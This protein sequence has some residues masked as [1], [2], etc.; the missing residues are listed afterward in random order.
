MEARLFFL[1]M[2]RKSIFKS[3]LISILLFLVLKTYSQYDVNDFNLASSA[4]LISPGCFQLTPADY[5]KGGAIWYK[6]RIDLSSDFEI[7][8]SINLGDL[9]QTGADGISFLLQP[10]SNTLGGFGGGLGYM[11]VVPSLAVEFD[12]WQNDDPTYDHIALVKNGRPEHTINP[13]NTLQGPFELMPQ[14]GNAEDGKFHSVKI[15]WNAKDK[16]FT[17]SF[18]GIVKIQY[19]G[20]IVKDIF[21]SNPYVYW[22]FTAA[23]AAAINDHRVCFTSYSVVDQV[24]PVAKLTTPS[25]FCNNI[26]PLQILNDSKENQLNV[27]YKWYVNNTLVSEDKDLDYTSYKTGVFQL[28]LLV[29][30]DNG[31]RDSVSKSIEIVDTPSVKLLLGSKNYFC[32]DDSLLISSISSPGSGSITSS[33]WYK[34]Q[35][36]MTSSS[37]SIYAKEEGEYSLIIKNSNGCTSSSNVSVQ[38]KLKPVGILKGPSANY[39]CQ[40]DSVLITAEGGKTYQWYRDGLI[41]NGVSESQ[42]YAKIAGLYTVELISEFGCINKLAKSIPLTF[43][44]KPIADFSYSNYCIN[45]PILFKN[46]SKSDKSDNPT[47]KWNFGDGSQASIADNPQKVYFKSSNYDVQLVVRSSLCQNLIDSVKKQILIETP[48]VGVSYTPINAIF[49]SPIKFSARD[50]G[51]SYQW[52]PINYLDAPNSR[53]I[54][55]TPSSQITYKIVIASKSGCLTVDTLLV[56]VFDNSD[57]L[58]P[59]AFSPNTDGH[60]DKLDIFLVGL[61]KMNYFK[62]FNRW[63][64]LLYETTDHTQRWDGLYKSKLQQP[65][66]YVWVA[67]GVSF[68]DEKILRRGQFLLL[69]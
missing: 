6:R 28:K 13:S 27:S 50:F 59:K 7:N 49:N 9:D 16:K 34:N 45:V 55:I 32:E 57:I 36:Q 30:A 12:T 17:L 11:N 65:D 31:C 38:Q 5:Y 39:I 23:T 47:Y 3:G 22:G 44:E 66:T 33:L 67:E 52:H 48:A 15:L 61:K 51:N 40:N 2:F 14:K 24:C 58:V 62:I 25:I 35:T 29:E 54:T 53:T 42:L 8:A 4:R 63:G 1:T 18:D 64:Q 43:I 41:L 60:N 10:L 68:K 26:Q 21:N 56:R 69:R 20:D 37:S 46:Q 19:V